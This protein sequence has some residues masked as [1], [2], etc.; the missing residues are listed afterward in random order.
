MTVKRRGGKTA[1]IS[2]PFPGGNPLRRAAE[3]ICDRLRRD[4]RDWKLSRELTQLGCG[5]KDCVREYY[6]R[7]IE[8]MLLAALLCAAALIAVLAAGRGRNRTV[9][10]GLLDR[11]GYGERGTDR[12]L[13]LTISGEAESETVDVHIEARRYTAPEAGRLLREAEKELTDGLPGANGSLDE[14]RTALR[15]P[16]VLLNGTVSAEYYITPA[17]MIEEDGSIVG[18]PGEEGTLITITAT[19]TCQD[20]Q[21]TVT[22]CARVYP[23]LRTEQEELRQKI[24]DAVD[25]ARTEDPSASQMQLPQEVDGRALHWS[26]PRDPAARMIVLLILIAPAWLWIHK[27]SDVRDRAKKREAQLELDY[28]QLL[29][30]LTMLLSAGLTIRGSFTRIAA[31][32]EAQRRGKENPGSVSGARRQ[33]TGG[34]FPRQRQSRKTEDRAGHPDQGQGSAGRRGEVRYVYEE[35]LLTLR[36][37]QS[38]VPEASAYEN[39]GRRCALPSYI[40]LGSLLAQN[41]KK[42]SKGL[43]ALLE[44]EAVLSLEQH[45]MAARK[46]GEK[47]GIRMLLPMILMFGVVLIILMVPAFLTMQ[48]A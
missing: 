33:K 37:M 17:G 26:Y 45:R 35:M 19:L 8:A 46:L 28:S 23:P 10:G 34:R 25:R 11:P 3:A 39:F 30:K 40:K 12:S 5:K 27:D 13:N 18:T 48:A 44:H 22:C 43:T 47:A 7:K 15:I 21:R 29:W 20:R 6:V 38:G 41:L 32:Y 31:Q 16:A 14:V 2:R 1:R 4:D 36:E 42:G 24:R 9:A